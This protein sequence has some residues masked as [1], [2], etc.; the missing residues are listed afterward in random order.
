MNMNLVEERRM[1]RANM[2]QRE[3]KQEKKVLTIHCLSPACTWERHMS[4]F[5]RLCVTILF[6]S[7]LFK[8][9]KEH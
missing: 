9:H 3:G 7:H 4:R 2:L 8:C 1:A 5:R 6:S